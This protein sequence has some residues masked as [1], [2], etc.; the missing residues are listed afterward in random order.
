[1]TLQ[2]VLTALLLPPLLLVL[3]QMA[4]A[5]LAWRGSRG[6]LAVAVLAGGAQLLLA[7]PF[8]AGML[9]ASLPVPPPVAGASPGAIV[10]LGGDGVRTGPGPGGGT[11]VGALTLERLRAGAVLHRATGLPLLVTG[12]PNSPGAEPLGTVMARS[13]G[14]DFGTPARWVEPAA[15]DTRDNAVLSAALLRPE[16]IGTVLLVTHAWHM[17]R[18]VEAFRRAGL[19]PLPAPVRLERVPDGQAGD[20]VPR[21]D[22]LA[23]SWFALREW[24]GRL[25]Y[26]IRD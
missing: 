14:T 22:H 20:W 1:M 7:T 24:A 12:G 23:A 15:R 4:G 26:A 5:G 3:L 17:A 21:P 8:A 25:V 11:D 18:A 2:A 19:V 6:G 13:L 10:V 16:G 9:L